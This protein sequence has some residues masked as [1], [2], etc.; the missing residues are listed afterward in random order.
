MV[1]NT[2]PLGAVGSARRAY[3]GPGFSQVNEP[4][5]KAHSGTESSVE[6]TER[7]AQWESFAFT[8]PA[9][10]VVKVENQSYG[11]ESGDHRYLVNVA[12]GEAVSCSCPA[13]EYHPGACKHRVAVENETAVMQ[14]ASASN[15]ELAEARQ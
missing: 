6:R 1:E 13:D 9:A 5:S 8:V 10:N 12:A 11:D 15:D 7:R 14:A 4:M 2:G 3:A